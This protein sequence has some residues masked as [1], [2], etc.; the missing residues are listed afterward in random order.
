MSST[1]R[2]PFGGRAVLAMLYQGKEAMAGTTSWPRKYR[3]R[4]AGLTLVEL[5]LVIAI[6][7]LLAGVAIPLYQGYVTESRIGRAIKDIRTI[8]VVLR[9]LALDGD[10]PD[11]LGAI[12]ISM[13]DP[14]GS[15]Y[16][17]LRIQG[18]PPS[19]RGQ[20]RKDRNLV[21]LNTDFDLYS[22][23]ED[24]RTVPPLTA[25]ASHD[26]V[27]RADNGGFVGLGESY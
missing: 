24:G 1:V 19:V 7:A 6:I 18:A 4:S 27:V 10:L 12:G 16:Q 14:W 22:T 2:I 23:G 20:V 15:P 11:S 8:E 5:V 17:Y 25:P 13:T 3:A 26:D 21:P 9:N